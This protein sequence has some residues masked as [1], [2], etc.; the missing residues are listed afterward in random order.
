M[1]KPLFSIK[2]FLRCTWTPEF[3]C[4]WADWAE[5]DIFLHEGTII[6]NK[7][8]LSDVKVQAKNFIKWELWLLLKSQRQIRGILQGVSSLGV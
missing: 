6:M 7:T 4:Y 5:D 8:A 2:L 3:W 1:K